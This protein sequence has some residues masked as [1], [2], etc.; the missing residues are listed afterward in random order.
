MS[1]AM[2]Y[3]TSLNSSGATRQ[4]TLPV[5][6]GRHGA[7]LDEIRTIPAPSSSESRMQAAV[8]GAESADPYDDVACTD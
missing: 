4:S 2:S 3:P 8:V 6:R 1:L 5:A 7:E